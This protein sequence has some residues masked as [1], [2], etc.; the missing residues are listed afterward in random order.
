MAAAR[1]NTPPAPAAPNNFTAALATG[2]QVN[3]AWRDNA[4]NETGFVLER[5]ENGGPFSQIAAPGVS[6]G[7]GATLTFTDTAVMTGANYSYRVKAVYVVPEGTLSSA[8]ATVSISVTTPIAPTNLSAAIASASSINVSWRDNSNNESSFTVWVSV[9]SA[10]AT[11]AGTVTVTAAQGTATGGTVTFAHTGLASGHTYA[12][13][14]TATN[15]L[16][17]S[18]PSNTAAV[19]APV[20]PTNVTATIASSTSIRVSWRD[21]SNNETSFEIWSSVGWRSGDPDRNG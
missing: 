17:E 20:A 18:G 12:Y 15:V 3:L 8:Y 16:G 11:Q 7:T 10:A 13:Y 21:A 6:T 1:S 5:S 4:N 19:T 9:D 14:A 2:P